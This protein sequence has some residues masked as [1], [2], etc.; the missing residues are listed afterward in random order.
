M[1]WQ[2]FG[3]IYDYPGSADC[4]RPAERIGRVRGVRSKGVFDPSR[5]RYYATINV[6]NKLPQIGRV[7]G[8]FVVFRDSMPREL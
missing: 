6:V 3:Q 5:A 1:P 7:T 8:G 4:A 2:L